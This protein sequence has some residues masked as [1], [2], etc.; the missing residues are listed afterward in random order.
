MPDGYM[1]PE[2]I[3]QDENAPAAP[4]RA[5]REQS[6]IQ[7]PYVDLDTAIEV[8]RVMRDRGGNAPFTRDQ[9]AAAIGHAVSSGS[10]ASKVHAARMFG[11]LDNPTPGRFRV[12]QL[13]FDAV[14]PD[15][16]RATAGRV[17]AFLRVPLFRRTYDD[18]R[19]KTLPSRPHGLERIFSEY[20][21]APK[22]LGNARLTFDRSARQAGFFESGDDRLVAPFV[23]VSPAEGERI[24]EPPAPRPAQPTQRQQIDHSQPGSARHHL[25][26]GLFE[27]LPDPKSEW[28]FA[29]RSRWLRLAASMFDV[30][31]TAK[32]NKVFVI[33]VKTVEDQTDGKIN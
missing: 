19:G 31:Y 29:E 25:V 28:S 11:L 17:E 8:A 27:A 21:V 4:T 23:I 13:G 26:E 1:N 20:G 10:Y 33:E 24:E 6:T 32:D 9:L 15:P 14:D 7:F 18:Y 16:H 22:R 5:T 3:R 30:L 12:S 2:D